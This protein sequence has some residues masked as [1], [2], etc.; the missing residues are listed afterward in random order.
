MSFKRLA[1]SLMAAVVLAFPMAASAQSERGT[2]TGVVMDSSKAAVPGV[3]ARRTCR[4][5]RTKSKPRFRDSRR[6]MSKGLS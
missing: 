4:P 1:A 6:R 5:A 3:S 2:I